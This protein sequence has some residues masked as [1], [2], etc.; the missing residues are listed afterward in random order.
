MAAT[1]LCKF[2][3]HKLV[4]K[5]FNL[6]TKRFDR[7]FLSFNLLLDMLHFQLALGVIGL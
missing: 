1:L 5:K 3:A 4:V 6:V 7:C 2:D